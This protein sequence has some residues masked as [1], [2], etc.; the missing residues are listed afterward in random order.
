MKNGYIGLIITSVMIALFSG[1]GSDFEDSDR[2]TSVQ[3][4]EGT[5]A[6]VENYY[7]QAIEFD[8]SKCVSCHT[9]GGQAGSTPLVLLDLTE[10]NSH[11][12]FLTLHSYIK[13]TGTRIIQK[14][15]GTLSHAGGSLFTST[16]VGIYTTF[17]NY[18]NDSTTCVDSSIS[19]VE[20]PLSSVSVVSPE[21][22]ARNASLVI[23]GE[24][25]TATEL[26]NA[27]SN[28]DAYLDTLLKE[29]DFYD[30]LKLRFND[31]F[32]TDRYNRSSDGINL[33][34]SNEFPQRRWYYGSRNNRNMLGETNTSARD[35][36]YRR[37]NS[38]T[39]YGVARAPLELIAHVV[40]EEKPFGEILTADYIMMNPYSSRTYGVELNGFT[41]QDEDDDELDKFSKD[42]FKELKIPGVPH[43]G[44]LT[45]IMFLNR[46][47]TTATNRNRH[48]SA[49]VQ[50]FFL[51]TDI[52]G[53]ADRPI[54]ASEGDAGIHNPTS[55]NAD[56]TVC[57]FVMD[58][59]AGA[60]Q[61]VF[62]HEQHEQSILKEL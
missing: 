55:N 20:I 25:P 46:F 53:L 36:K 34:D 43:A 29:D 22:M 50:L 49:K 62:L 10:A 4:D 45:D 54:N 56:C 51:D 33:M 17:I 26:T 47:P 15:D 52:L 19:V 24:T 16:D 14:N 13:A 23:L 2:R 9:A 3:S 42:N 35:K 1:C 58:P 57:H 32:L 48:R 8:L 39:N 11:D 27:S 38:K 28:L 59:I 31:V 21:A 30:W 44:L 60:M 61:K 12:N 7:K 37:V 6:C 18:A 5:V 40:R 41:L